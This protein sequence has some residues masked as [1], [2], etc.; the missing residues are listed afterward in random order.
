METVHTYHSPRG[1]HKYRYD[2][3]GVIIKS[4]CW[5]SLSHWT[6]TKFVNDILNRTATAWDRLR[7]FQRKDHWLIR[8]DERFVGRH[9][10]N[11]YRHLPVQSVKGSLVRNTI[12]ESQRTTYRLH[13][14]S[15]HVQRMTVWSWTE[16]DDIC[17]F[18]VLGLNR[19][20]HTSKWQHPFRIMLPEP[21]DWEG[22]WPYPVVWLQLF[23][24]DSALE[25]WFEIL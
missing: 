4:G 18:D 14:H 17:V 20:Y 12:L 1:T 21:C 19:G 23:S 8:C 24:L 2:T 10:R 9:P 6:Q 13:L 16:S 7:I 11:F 15:D 5:Q 25:P 22:G 3:V